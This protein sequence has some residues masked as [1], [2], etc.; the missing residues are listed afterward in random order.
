MSQFTSF[1]L[2]TP[3]VLVCVLACSAPLAAINPADVPVAPPADAIMAG[4]DE[5]AEM[6]QW[7]ERAFGGA[8]AAG[9]AVEMKVIR[10]DH[11][12]LHFNRSCIET[13]LRV[14]G[15]AFHRGL[16]THANSEIL[17][18]VPAGARRFRASVGVDDND[19]T[20]GRHGSVRFAVAAGDKELARTDVR[21]GG[22]EA[23]DVDVAL[24]GEAKQIR[25]LVDD[26]GDGPSH[27]QADW[28]D[29]RFVLDDGKDVF[30]DQ[31]RHDPLV[32][33]SR[34]PFSFVYGGKSSAELLGG[35][36]RETTPSTAAGGW[37]ERQIV[38]TDPDTRL[39]VQATVRVCSAFPAA[40]WV[41]HLENAGEKD[42]P[43]LENIQALDATVRANFAR[44]AVRFH[45]IR[46]DDCS[47][48]SFLPFSQDLAA[49]Q[50][51]R[52]APAGGRS[53]NGTFPFFTLEY[54]GRGL[55]CGIGWSGQ[56]AAALT[57]AENG[58]VRLSAGMEK[59]RLRLRPGET[60]R[61]P[62]ILL[63]AWRGDRRDAH[64]RFRR[65]LLHH[66]LPREGNRPLAMP[67]FWQNYDRYHDRADWACEAGQLK[68]ADFA[69]RAGCDFLWLDAAWFPGNFPNGVGNWS[70]KPAEFPNGLKPVSDACHKAGLKFIVWFEPER[71]APGS[72]IAR[73]HPEF[74]FGGAKG[75]LFKLSDPAARK[76]MT[77]LLSKRISEFG[78]DWYRNDFNIDPLSFW[79]AADEPDRQGMTEI[80]YVEGHYE[81]WDELLRRHAGLIIDNCAS[82]GRRIDLETMMRSVPL[83][84]SDTAC[85]PGGLEWNQAQACG[86]GQ[87]IPLS[88]ICAWTST[89]YDVRAA[90]GAGGIFQLAY[91]EEG[92][93]MQAAQAA[94]AE[95]RQNAKYW[96][97]DLY[98]LTAVNTEQGHF[99]AWQLHRSDL[100]AGIVLAFRRPEC[101]NPG[102]I[103]ALR[104]IDPAGSYDV[105]FVDEQRAVT[106]AIVPGKD[107]AELVLKIPTRPA[108]LLVRY[109]RKPPTRSDRQLRITDYELPDRPSRSCCRRSAEPTTNNQQPTTTP[110][111]ARGPWRTWL[112]GL[113]GPWPFRPAYLF[114]W[115][116]GPVS[117]R[118]PWR[119]CRVPVP[120]RGGG[121]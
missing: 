61:T 38:W 114:R 77:E 6:A 32:D 42:S 46:G 107:L 52:L 53:S 78:M 30:L 94:I 39:R 24:P 37:T 93:D 15:R 104:A 70:P 11:S 21:R 17:V 44:R 29:A 116:P 113:R 121:G 92:F 50:A 101:E 55:V 108:S 67:I 51:I 49:G 73:E 82:G 100:N 103:A 25:L 112:A 118:G 13:P 87:Y 34:L 90:A 22:Q 85:R 115:R 98:P 1:V 54:A 117:R 27:D 83:W 88:Q 119:G 102:I 58:P 65:L 63:M 62:R 45:S 66:Y 97:G 80:R 69:R 81:M 71:V 60:I 89:A 9:A 16:G 111:P 59:T 8:A 36:K 110:A 79:R 7:A 105:E 10:Q 3:L 68:A 47:E 64:N 96:Y 106:K 31:G 86:F 2:R 109:R 28:A 84:R 14:G 43:I 23:V 33:A 18:K 57:R 35:W 5:V 91:L 56:W 99:M 74:V 40:D 72:Q 76:W 41:L 26:A 20:D 19:N 12:D 120:L 4:A 48:R 75:G 95:A